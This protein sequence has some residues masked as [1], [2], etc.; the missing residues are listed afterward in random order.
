M[1]WVITITARPR[2]FAP[3]CSLRTTYA[4]ETFLVMSAT[5]EYYGATRGVA[6]PG[7]LEVEQGGILGLGARHLYVPYAAILNVTPGQAVEVDCLRDE[8]LE[9]FGEKPGWLD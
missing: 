1:L 5:S 3:V 6:G 4:R 7:Y 9:R 2:C 8:C